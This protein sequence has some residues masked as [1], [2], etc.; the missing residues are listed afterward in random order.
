MLRD[1]LDRSAVRAAWTG[2]R[3][4]VRDPSADPTDTKKLSRHHVVDVVDGGLVTIAGGKWCVNNVKGYC[5][6][7]LSSCIYIYVERERERDLRWDLFWISKL[8]G[9]HLPTA[10]AVSPLHWAVHFLR[11][12]AHTPALA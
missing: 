3:P 9:W 10:L 12:L 6:A 2:L 5:H 1:K 4:L 7:M 11:L 8:R